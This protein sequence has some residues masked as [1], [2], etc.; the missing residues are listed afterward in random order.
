MR[1]VMMVADDERYCVKVTYEGL[2]VFSS[3]GL[4]DVLVIPS[5]GSIYEDVQVAPESSDVRGG[6]EG[7]QGQARHIWK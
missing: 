4:E 5:K 3:G 7:R 6:L 1:R 2:G